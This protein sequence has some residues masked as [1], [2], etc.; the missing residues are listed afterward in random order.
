MRGEHALVAPLQL[1]AREPAHALNECAFNLPFIQCRIQRAAHIVQD[2]NAL[3]FHL[4]GQRVDSHLRTRGAVGKVIERSA[5][6]G[7]AVPVNF[8]RFVEA[9][10]RE[11]NASKP[12]V[13]NQFVE[14]HVQHR[15]VAVGV[16]AVIAKANSGRVHI[17]FFCCKLGQPITQLSTCVFGCHAVQIAATG[18]RRSA[19][20]GHF[21]GVCGRHPNARGINAQFLRHNLPDFGEQTLAHLGAAVIDNHRTI[22]INV[23]QRARLI[24]MCGVK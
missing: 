13:V 16:N 17:P 9:L 21:A 23:D 18:G 11:R 15:A 12:C 1:F 3:H 20:V 6:E 4:A 19:S 2:V 22:R 10:R 24:E 8:W 5:L 7:I 14:R